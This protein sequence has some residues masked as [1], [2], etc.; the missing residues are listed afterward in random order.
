MFL[1]LSDNIYDYYENKSYEEVQNAYVSDV[2]HRIHWKY[3]C[4]TQ[5]IEKPAP[6]KWNKKHTPFE[7]T[8]EC[9][10]QCKDCD[11]MQKTIPEVVTKL[12]EKK[13]KKT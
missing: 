12:I 6:D 1:N 9:V 8:L 3:L 13:I 10:K 4:N 11:Y 2:K 7:F 5:V